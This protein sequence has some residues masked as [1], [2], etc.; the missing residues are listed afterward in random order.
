MT[1]DTTDSLERKIDQLVELASR[2]QEENAALRERESGLVR[3]RGQLLE[4]NEQARTRVENMIN[5]LKALN[6]EG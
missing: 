5:R 1:S 4:K 2:L 3:E 6:P